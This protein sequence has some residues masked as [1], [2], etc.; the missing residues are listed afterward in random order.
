MAKITKAGGPS[1][2][3]D[4][5]NDPA[6]SEVMLNHPPTVDRGDVVPTRFQVGTVSEVG[7]AS[8]AGSNSDQSSSDGSNS[9]E[10]QTQT[11]PGRARTMES[12][13]SQSEEPTNSGAH[14]TDGVGPETETESTEDEVPPYEDWLKADLEAECRVRQLPVSGTKDELVARLYAYDAEAEDAE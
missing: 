12:L 9:S 5:L 2:S 4:E 10:S 3:D 13:S 8:S 14:S 7:G 6:P 1:F 11:R